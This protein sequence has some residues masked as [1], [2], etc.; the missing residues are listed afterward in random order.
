VIRKLLDTVG[1]VALALILALIV[2]A[3]ATNAEN[4]AVTQW[5]P[6]QVPIEI[7]NQPPGSVIVTKIESTAQ[8]RITVPRDSWDTVRADDFVAYIDLARVPFDQSTDVPVVVQ[9]VKKGVLLNAHKPASVTVRLEA[10]KSAT[11]PVRANIVDSPPLGYVARDPVVDPTTVSVGGPA[12]SVARV[13]YASVDVWLRGARES[14]VRS[15]TPTAMDKDGSPVADVTV[16]PTSVTVKVDLAQRANFKPSVPIRAQLVG[17][18][19]PLY[20]VSNITVRPTSVT[21][22]GLPSVLEQIPGYIETEPVDISNATATVSRR[23]ALKLP[24]GVTVV[25]ESATDEAAQS[26]QVDVEVAPVTGGRTMK[27]SVQTQGLGPQ[28]SATLSPTEIDVYLSGPLVQ[29]QGLTDKD[30]LAS[31]NLVDVGPG[32]HR[33]K[34]TVSVPPGVEIKGMVPEAVEVQVT[35][36]PPT[37]EPAPS[38]QPTAVPTA[39]ASSGNG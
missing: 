4:P 18:V 31:V 32:T 30:V 7:R 6:V 35:G 21:L 26:V 2:W 19:A 24:A 11:V 5:A 20:W 3:G 23:V 8:V 25:P 27:I 12:A 13:A 16:T 33:V 29:L 1:S 28:N 9:V 37:P 22:V 38:P 34:P 36:P 39:A 17:E 14:V 10:Y 15:L